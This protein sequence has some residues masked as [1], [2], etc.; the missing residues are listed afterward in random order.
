DQK[1]IRVNDYSIGIR[2]SLDS[3]MVP[4]AVKI[5]D[6]GLEDYPSYLPLMSSRLETAVAA[7]RQASPEALKTTLELMEFQGRVSQ[8]IF[9]PQ[10]ALAAAEI[11]AANGRVQEARMM[12]GAVLQSDPKNEGAKKILERLKKRGG[13]MGVM[14]RGSITITITSTSTSTI[15]A[16]ARNKKARDGKYREVNGNGLA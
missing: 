4:L 10:S 3:G 5:N 2:A 6:W 1:F 7:G 11:L 9:S 8:P 13:I 15:R 16:R 14:G 12:A